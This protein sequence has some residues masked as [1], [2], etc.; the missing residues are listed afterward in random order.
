[1][2]A[3]RSLLHRLKC[4]WP[5]GYIRCIY[6]SE[7]EVMFY[8][9]VGWI[10]C[11]IMQ[12]LLHVFQQRLVGGLGL[13][14]G[15]TYSILVQIQEFLQESSDTGVKHQLIVWQRG[16]RPQVTTQASNYPTCLV[17]WHYMLTNDIMA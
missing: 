3:I 16:L 6:T 14:Q 4:L 7:Q 15:S 12:K 11:R 5:G 10:V 2:F 17:V 9:S 13:S 8:L 1:M